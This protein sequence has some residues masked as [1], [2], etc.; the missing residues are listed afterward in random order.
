MT[1][2]LNTTRN[3]LENSLANLSEAQLSPAQFDEIVS[4]I[5]Q[6]NIDQASSLIESALAK[7]IVDIRLIVYYCYA[8]FFN[9]GIKSFLDTFPSLISLIQDHWDNLKPSNKKEK[10]VQN[11]LNWYFSNAVSKLKYC[12]KQAKAGKLEPIWILSTSEIFSTELDEIV[13]TLIQ[14]QEFFQEKWTQTA[15]NERFMHLLHLVQELRIFTKEE[16]V[17]VEVVVEAPI[18]V[19][20]HS[21]SL[22]EPLPEQLPALKQQEFPAVSGK[23]ESLLQKLQ[24]FEILI[25][26]KEFLKAALV[27]KDIEQIIENFDPIEYFPKL[28]S[29]YFSLISREVSHLSEHWENQETETLQLKY[30]K[31]LYQTDLNRFIE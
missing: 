13:K 6:E 26:K 22:P 10:Q 17:P 9:L 18:V 14:F 11:S 29:S 28:F 1:L 7:G 16:V 2:S 24:I 27:S 8:Q 25:Q 21:E 5:E 30:L 3:I 15:L 23:M 12:S 31:K 4:L 19:E 20:P